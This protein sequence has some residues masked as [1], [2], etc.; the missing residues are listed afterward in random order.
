MEHFII[1]VAR[2]LDVNG[3]QHSVVLRKFCRRLKAEDL[4]LLDDGKLTAAKVVLEIYYTVIIIL[5]LKLTF[6]LT[7]SIFLRAQIGQQ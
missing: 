6:Y 2:C 3:E 7:Y 4:A 1:V 5:R